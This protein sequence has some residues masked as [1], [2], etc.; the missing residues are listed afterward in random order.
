[1]RWAGVSSQATCAPRIEGAP[2]STISPSD[3]K[4]QS[5]WVF[6]AEET[7]GH[8]RQIEQTPEGRVFHLYNG[9]STRPI[10][11][12]LVGEV[13]RR[14]LTPDAAAHRVGLIQSARPFRGPRRRDL[15][16]AALEGTTEQRMAAIGTLLDWW[17]TAPQQEA[18]AAA[19]LSDPDWSYALK[20]VAGLE[21]RDLGELCHV[22][23]P[24]AR[25]G[26]GDHF[27][28]LRSAGSRDVDIPEPVLPDP[29]R[30]PLAGFY[31]RKE[32]GVAVHGTVTV[33]GPLTIVDAGRPADLDDGTTLDVP[34]G[35]WTVLQANVL[36]PGETVLDLPNGGQMR[37]YDHWVVL[38]HGQPKSIV[39][40]NVP[41]TWGQWARRVF[42]SEEIEYDTRVSVDGRPPVALRPVGDTPYSGGMLAIVGEPP[43]D[44]SAEGGTSHAVALW[45]WGVQFRMGTSSAIEVWMGQS[46]R[47][48]VVAIA[49]CQTCLT[50]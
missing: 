16:L 50:R 39:V 6:R 43:E 3:L 26:I 31:Q 2:V 7:L 24:E 45:D 36:P 11:E 1:M 13:L 5:Y 21:L 40:D 19:A 37:P 20:R 10:P 32:V 12:A 33:P 9:F 34:A 27:V 4:E 30:P 29:P 42:R 47:D 25:D 41:E 8:I 23:Y 22:L 38:V 46:D 14:P 35:T 44:A 17:A 48:I 15:V 18:R 49:T 28:A